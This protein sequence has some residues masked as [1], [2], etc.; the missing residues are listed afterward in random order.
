MKRTIQRVLR[1][2]RRL[3]GRSPSPSLGETFTS[4]ADYWE[5]RYAAG[6]TSGAGS[7]GKF[8][9]FK[10]GML[11]DFVAEKEVRSVIEFGCGDGR[12]LGLAR[13]PDYTGLDVS[14]AAV[15]ACREMFAGDPAKRFHLYDPERFPGEAG[16][17][18]AEL[19][20]SLD[21]IY[22]L[23]EDG[24]FETHMKHLFGSAERFVIIYSSDHDEWPKRHVRHRRFSAHAAAHFPGWALAG[25]VPNPYPA[26]TEGKEGACSD[27]YIY[28]RA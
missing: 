26:E 13:Y 17:F 14:E 19:S 3:L 1:R 21:V 6:Y 20:L 23:V 9:E 5:R 25:R 8:A 22:H 4:S 18:R 15:R 11:N 2:T 16:E 10:A 27:F 28:E 12:Q 24:V 7:Y